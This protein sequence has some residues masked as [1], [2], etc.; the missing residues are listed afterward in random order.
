MN[1]WVRLHIT[2]KSN[3][4]ARAYN[5][6]DDANE[7]PSNCYNIVGNYQDLKENRKELSIHADIP[8]AVGTK[9]AD[10][11]SASLRSER[12]K[13]FNLI[14]GI[15]SDFGNLTH[16]GTEDGGNFHVLLVG[17]DNK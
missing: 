1:D 9:T 10:K 17:G 16:D 4:T 5:Y 13:V 2:G 6:I 12:K 11:L 15:I 14:P 7:L 8:V 3:I